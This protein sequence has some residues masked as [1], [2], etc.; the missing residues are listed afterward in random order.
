M[1]EDIL[2]SVEFLYSRV[3]VQISVMLTKVNLR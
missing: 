3:S 2:H 1:K